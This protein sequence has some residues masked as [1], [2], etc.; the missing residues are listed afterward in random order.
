MSLT[1]AR[2][3]IVPSIMFVYPIVSQKLK[4][5]Y[6]RSQ[7]TVLYSIDINLNATAI[8]TFHT[9]VSNDMQ[10]GAWSPIR[11]NLRSQ[12]QLQKRSLQIAT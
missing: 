4:R 7:R 5:I 6:V 9:V 8:P 10:A 3:S 2:R 1:T 12:I 11:Q